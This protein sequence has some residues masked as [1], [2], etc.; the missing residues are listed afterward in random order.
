[1]LAVGLDEPPHERACNAE[2]VSGEGGGPA[3]ADHG[4]PPRLQRTLG[5]EDMRRGILWSASTR[6]RPPG[7]AIRRAVH[8][9]ARSSVP[10]VPVVVITI[11]EGGRVRQLVGPGPIDQCLED[12]ADADALLHSNGF[13]PCSPIVIESQA[14]DG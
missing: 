7:V 8:L 14:Q 2:H 6:S 3:N 13:D 5:S 11:A 10:V 9:A 12:G 4:S 1:M